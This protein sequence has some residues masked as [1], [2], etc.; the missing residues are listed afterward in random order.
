MPLRIEVVGL[1]AGLRLIIALGELAHVFGVAEVRVVIDDVAGLERPARE[2]L[3]L[4]VL[5]ADTVHQEVVPATHGGFQVDDGRL[6]GGHAVY[7]LD[8]VGHLH[9]GI[10]AEEL[11]LRLAFHSLPREV[12][13]V[14]RFDEILG[15]LEGDFDVAGGRQ[16][17]VAE[18]GDMAVL[19]Q[20]RVGGNAE[21][22]GSEDEHLALQYV[23][24]G[25][26]GLTEDVH[27]GIVRS[28]LHPH[29]LEIDGV[30]LGRQNV[31]R[32]L[33]RHVEL[34]HR[35][36]GEEL[37]YL[38]A[39]LQLLVIISEVDLLGQALYLASGLALQL[40]GIGN[41]SVTD[42]IVDAPVREEFVHDLH[43]RE[44]RGFL[45]RHA[46]ALID[47]VV[48]VNLQLVEA[49]ADHYLGT[50]GVPL[51][52]AGA[53]EAAD[54]G[55]L[56]FVDGE[57][58]FAYLHRLAL[59]LLGRLSGGRMVVYL[60]TRLALEVCLAKTLA[61][62]EVN[63]IPVTRERHRLTLLN[64]GRHSD[65]QI[66]AH[67][68]L[69]LDLRPSDGVL[70]VLG[71]EG[72]DGGG[73]QCLL[74][75]GAVAVIEEFHVIFYLDRVA[76]HT[77]AIRVLGAQPCHGNVGRL[78]HLACTAVG[79]ETGGGQPGVRKIVER[80]GDGCTALQA[81]EAQID[82]VVGI[83]IAVIIVTTAT[84]RRT[85][86]TG[87][88]RSSGDNGSAQTEELIG[89]LAAIGYADIV[90]H[91]AVGIGRCGSDLCRIRGARTH[92]LDD[93]GGYH[94]HG[95]TEVADLIHHGVLVHGVVGL[96]AGEHFDDAYG[97]GVLQGGGVTCYHRSLP[98]ELRREGVQ[99]GDGLQALA[100]GRRRQ[101]LR[102]L[103]IVTD[104]EHGKSARGR[105]GHHGV[106][107]RGVPA[108]GG[109]V[110]LVLSLRQKTE[111][112]VGIV[113]EKVG[114]RTDLVHR[115]VVEE[116]AH[117][118]RSQDSSTSGRHHDGELGLAR[119]RGAHTESA[120]RVHL[121]HLHDQI[122]VGIILTR[123]GEGYVEIV[124]GLG[125][126]EHHLGRQDRLYGRYRDGNVLSTES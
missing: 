112:A 45:H 82:V 63:D 22:R 60:D 126:V 120:G 79:T 116:A 90:E 7:V 104:I 119:G 25:Q 42:E 55:T 102:C 29:D 84:T 58:V 37:A 38:L 36:G 40:A 100:G 35:A 18:Q 109:E 1:Q 15:S 122:D 83:C 105:A 91:G 43:A 41:A 2:V 28:E 74:A 115:D 67:L 16:G 85:G 20:E 30:E 50:E 95:S 19:G 75:V 62:T 71:V 34:L 32:E 114:R 93:G 99:L 24:L 101:E 124:G 66:V 110:E 117:L 72:I 97:V 65:H 59:Q 39:V 121:L 87:S 31:R 52:A 98:S 80:V 103:G 51:H 10:D 96:L 73:A 11:E 8:E 21:A 13:A 89:A 48:L 64:G 54:T 69:V 81:A 17:E 78:E 107:Q 23:A 94:T 33:H 88:A 76:A 92:L 70:E 125:D 113:R 57:L 6:V 77:L 26:R 106:G 68:H 3:H 27:R 123:I 86:G 4:E 56:G 53:G 47:D 61:E 49:D 108:V 46:F 111:G 9:V 118:G 5:D 14:V 44:H 12:A